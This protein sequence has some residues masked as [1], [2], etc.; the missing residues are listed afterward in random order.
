M[1]SNSAIGNSRGNC[2]QKK[3]SIKGPNLQSSSMCCLTVQGTRQPGK[4]P[5]FFFGRDFARAVQ[6][7][8]GRFQMRLD[9]SAS[10]TKKGR[11]TWGVQ[12]QKTVSL[13]PPT[14]KLST[15]YK[16]PN[17][18][19]WHQHKAIAL[20]AMLHQERLKDSKANQVLQT[21]EFSTVTSAQTVQLLSGEPLEVV[22]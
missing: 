14:G 13:A 3:R 15:V 16:A 7:T 5:L 4:V 2:P 9:C 21:G 10:F 22:T 11:L 12:G 17:G 1:S 20:Q 18:T 19:K 8:L 6:T